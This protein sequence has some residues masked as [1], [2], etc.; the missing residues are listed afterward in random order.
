MGL[1]KLIKNRI[2]NILT[3]NVQEKVV[4]N[5][6]SLPP[7][8]YLK[9]RIAIVTGGT[10]GI[11][12]AIA[13][14]FANAGADVVITSR[15]YSKVLSVA[16]EIN[17]ANLSGKIYGF[18]LDVTE[19]KDLKSKFA[20]IEELVGQKTISILVNNAG[21]DGGSFRNTTED[22]YDK[23]METNLK[24]AFFMSQVFADYVISHNIKANILNIVSS[25]GIRPAVSP[26]MLS[27]WGLR[28]LTE[29][30]ARILAPKGIIVNG[31]APGP[32]ATAMQPSTKDGDISWPLN[33]LGR[34]AVPEEI[35]N[36]A[37]FLVS[38]MGQTIIGDIIYMSGGG[39]IITNEDY[40]YKY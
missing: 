25:S 37:V 36:M 35:A 13:I 27:K 23:V 3:V 28:G 4:A 26:Y 39:G 22:V 20:E 33:L 14:A 5:I 6:V 29:G 21:I 19:T 11:G 18:E 30:L 9:S 1:K 7:N 8:E 40:N 12:K 2:R 32:T 31:I 15:Y 17:N 16:E 34:M 10:G 38:N 24:G